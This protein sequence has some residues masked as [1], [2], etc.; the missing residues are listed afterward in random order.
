MQLVQVLFQ[1]LLRAI[2]IAVD[3]SADLL[4]D[5]ASSFG[6]CLLVLGDSATQEDFALLLVIGEGATRMLNTPSLDHVSRDLRGPLY[7]V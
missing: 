1:N 2:V 7:I 3:D 4:V 6:G 5:R